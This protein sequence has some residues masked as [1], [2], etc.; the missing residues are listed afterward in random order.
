[1]A[2]TNYNL[3]QWKNGD[4]FHVIGQLNPAFTAIDTTMKSNASAAASAQSQATTAASNAASAK[5]AAQTAQA[6]ANKALTTAQSAKT[7]A[8]GKVAYG[9]VKLVEDESGNGV[10][11][12]LGVVNA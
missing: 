10:I 2:T 6:T 3:P 1:M 5:S 12:T 11:V 7:S 9:K 8:D 4:E